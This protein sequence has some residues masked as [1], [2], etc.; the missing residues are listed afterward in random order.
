MKAVA[1]HGAQQLE[2]SARQRRHDHG[3]CG[4][5]MGSV[6]MRHHGRQ[7]RTHLL[8]GQ[9]T[10]RN[11]EDREESGRWL[12][13]A[14]KLT[15]VRAATDDYEATQG[16]RGAVVGM[17]VELR[18]KFDDALSVGPPAEKFVGGQQAGHGGRRR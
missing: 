13:A 12:E 6:G 16:C 17:P 9:C 1:V 14:G 4:D 8:R 10:L 7:G 18:G 3:A 5:V 15:A 11:E 2:A